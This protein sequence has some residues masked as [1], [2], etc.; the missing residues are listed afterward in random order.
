[1]EKEELRKQ[2]K[3]I[4]KN[5]CNVEQK[6]RAIFQ[7]IIT[8]SLLSHYHTILIYC[9]RKDEV[10]TLSL[11]RYFLE[12]KKDVFLPRCEGQRIEFYQINSL[13]DLQ[14]GAFHLLEPTTS[15]KLDND[16]NSICFVPGICFDKRGY[17]IGYGGGFYDRFLENYDGFS[18]GLTY[19]DCLLEVIPKTNYDIACD[20]VIT[21][22]EK[23]Y[24]LEK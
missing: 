23:I 13:D 2:Y 15:W 10:D 12:Q 14:E 17:R 22:K 8:D 16:K 24:P 4:R 3:Q 6:S 5:V 21:E 9:S 11:I 1:M 19:Q 7:S 18:V 20:M